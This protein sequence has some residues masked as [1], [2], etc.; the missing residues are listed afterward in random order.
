MQLDQNHNKL[1]KISL[2][3]NFQVIWTHF[4]LFLTIIKIFLYFS[5]ITPFCFF[6]SLP[7]FLSFLDEASMKLRWSLSPQL[8]SGRLITPSPGSAPLP[9]RS[10]PPRREDVFGPS[11][12]GE[13]YQKW[14]KL[15]MEG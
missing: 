11:Q 4:G 1:I 7:F 14:R 10:S 8:P 3:M 5:S 9:E 12:N 15:I 6:V 2:N 13:Q